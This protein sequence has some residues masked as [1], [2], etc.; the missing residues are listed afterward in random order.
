[1][2][3]IYLLNTRCSL[4]ER[5]QREAQARGFKV[6]VSE[7]SGV[8]DEN[9]RG[10]KG[11]TAICIFVNKK[12]EARQVPILV[13]N[14]TKLILHCSAGYDN[15][16][17]VELKAAGIRAARVP[18]YSPGSIAEY[19]IAQIMALAKNTHMSYV[20]T[21]KADFDITSLQ[22]LLLENKT[23]GIIG[24]GLIG[25]KT[26]EKISGLVER[27]VCF[28]VYPDKEWIGSLRNAEYTDLDTLF[29][30]SDFISIHVPLLPQTH[31]LIDED[32]FSKMKDD[33]VLINTS[34]GEIIHLPSLIKALESKKLWGVALDV[35]E[36]EK[37]Y[38]FHDK[39]KEGFQEHPD[40]A[41][42]ATFE[43][44]ILSSHIAFYTDQ[45]VEQ[46]TAKTLDNYEAFIGKVEE[47]KKS[48]IC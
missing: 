13:E 18:S 23:C 47:D 25:K 48:F 31:H 11:F 28:D 3:D 10:G 44:V 39:S 41:K 43:H 9:L 1:M 34:R 20:M 30:T 42:L 14:G 8:S 7:E 38:I 24:T 12:I 22:C 45:A 46:I 2:G 32:A 15:S 21:K 36:G 4:T 17:T 19:A 16:P 40:L 33:V 27:V 26:A 37:K 29:R 5:I 6:K 35:F